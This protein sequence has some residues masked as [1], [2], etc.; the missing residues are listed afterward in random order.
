VDLRTLRRANGLVADAQRDI[1]LAQLWGFQKERAAVV[2]PGG[3]GID[4]VEMHRLLEDSGPLPELNL[5]PGAAIVV[6]NPRGFRP[7]SVRNDVFFQ[8]VPL[9][10]CSAIQTWS[11]CALAWRVSQKR[12]NGCKAW[13]W[14]TVC[15]RCCPTCRR[16]ICG[17]C[18]PSAR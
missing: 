9:V 14:K 12:C 10:V 4:L 18:S 17:G 2:L 8:A 11:S 13:G 7:G 1:R 5:P 6:I 15:T 16:W 3:G